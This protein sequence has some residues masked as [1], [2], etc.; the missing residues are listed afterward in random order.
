MHDKHGDPLAY[1][2]VAKELTLT[3][4]IEPPWKPLRLRHAWADAPQCM[5][6]ASSSSN[7]SSGGGLAVPFAPFNFTLPINRTS[8]QL[9]SLPLFA[10]SGSIGGSSGDGD[11]FVSPP[12]V[13]KVRATTL[14]DA[15]LQHGKLAAARIQGWFAS[16]E[17]RALFAFTQT[18]GGAAALRDMTAE[19]TKAFPRYADEIRGLALGAGVAVP[20]VWAATLILELESLMEQAGL[21]R[22]ADHCSDIYATSAVTGDVSQGHNEDWSVEVKPFWYIV[23][24]T[25]VGTDADFSSCAGLSYV[26]HLQRSTPPTYRGRTFTQLDPGIGGLRGGGQQNNMLCQCVSDRSAPR[27]FDPSRPHPLT[28]SGHVA[29]GLRGVWDSRRYPGTLIGYAPTWS[30]QHGLYMTQNSLFPRRSSPTGLGCVFVQREAI[31]GRNV[32]SLDGVIAGLTPRNGVAWA[33]GAS[34]NVVSLTERKMANVEVYEGASS[35]FRVGS[36][37]SHFN[38]YVGPRPGQSLSCSTL[39]NLAT[40]TSDCCTRHCRLHQPLPGI[41]RKTHFCGVSREPAA[42]QFGFRA[43]ES[44]THFVAVSLPLQV[45]AGQHAAQGPRPPGPL[46]CPPAAAGRRAAPSLQHGGRDGPALRHRRQSLPDLPAD[47]AW[48]LRDQRN[49]QHPRRVVLRRP[50]RRRLCA[51]TLLR[52]DPRGID[53]SVYSGH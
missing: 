18:K 45:Q 22:G 9:P 38:E 50:S 43:D 44:P 25:A 6:F 16:P 21:R 20:Q 34:L 7:S 13:Y 27:P 17:M 36:N 51:R 49:R 3:V 41:G 31:C 42:H 4:V 40:R 35:V 48:E 24:Y 11:A 10:G 29:F 15:G 2:P 5:L 23:E 37:Y 52:P 30:R 26:A 47:H 33:D 1:D 53:G 28:L 46:D 14:Y 8:P 19:N 32:T 39:A 12:P